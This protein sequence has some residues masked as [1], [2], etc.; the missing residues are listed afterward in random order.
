MARAGQEFR[1]PAQMRAATCLSSMATRQ[2][3]RELGD[4]HAAVSG[5][6]FE[7]TAIGGVDAA[8]RVEAGER[9]DLVVLAADAIDKLV[10]AGRLR[11]RVDLVR[12][13]VAVAVRSGAPRPDIGDET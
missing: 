13:P 8:R 9:F 6:P 7:L 2:I 4:A 3:L 11:S 10:A 5:R 12:S 1:M